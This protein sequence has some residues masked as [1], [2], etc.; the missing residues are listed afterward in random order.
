MNF[1]AAG[2]SVSSLSERDYVGTQRWSEYSAAAGFV[3]ATLVCL[4]AAGHVL[5]WRLPSFGPVAAPVTQPRRAALPTVVVT[6]EAALADRL[7]ATGAENAYYER[8]RKRLHWVRTRVG[9]ATMLTPDLRS[10]MVLAK[11]AAQRAHLDEVGLSFM[12]VYGIINAETSWVPRPGASKDGTPNLGIAQFE[13]AT[14]RALGVD[15]PDDV[16]EAVHAAALNMKDA[17]VWSAS[18]LR[19][20][21]LTAA[22]RAEKLREGV[23]IYYNLSSRGRAVWNGRNTDRLPRETQ[24]HILN[25]RIGAQEAALLEAQFRASRFRAA[26]AEAVMTAGDP[27]AGG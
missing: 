12:D 9:H 19:G 26:H 5:P 15:D 20:L 14:A 18:R 11:S 24:L 1:A 8:L 22:Q 2:R 7:S 25:A 6:A 13:P 3:T 17:A 16:V 21:K 10:R 23:S 4:L 27:A